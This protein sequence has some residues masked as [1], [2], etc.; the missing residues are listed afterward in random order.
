[1]KRLLHFLL[2]VTLLLISGTPSFA[3]RSIGI[4]DPAKAKE[5]GIE[6]RA[7]PSGPEAAWIELEFK[8]EGAL[9]SFQHVELEINEGEK[10]LVGYTILNATKT[11]KG[12]HLIRLMVNRAFL[13]KVTLSIITGFPSNYSGNEL[14]LNEH[15]DVTKLK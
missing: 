13:S 5:W 7:T 3:L 1:M 6:I 9:K 4:I 12:T 15:V 2:L 11:E 8:A 14:R 10:L